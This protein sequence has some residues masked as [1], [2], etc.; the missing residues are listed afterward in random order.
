MASLNYGLTLEK[1]VES[2]FNGATIKAMLLTAAY[3][4][5]EDTHDFV[6][7]ASASEASGTG[8]T[9][10]GATITATVTYDAGTD[11][12]RVTFSSPNWPSSTITARYLLIYKELGTNAQ[13]EAICL[14]DN[15]SEVSSS[16]STF[17]FTISA[18]LVFQN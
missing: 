17:T 5:N 8:Y 7:D 16:N 11:Q 1:I 3:T 12:V 9:A 13:D 6:D 10:G 14:V 18:P 4:P 15:G 2:Y